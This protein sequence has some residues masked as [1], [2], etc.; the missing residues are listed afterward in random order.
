MARRL[1]IGGLDQLLY[2]LPL[3][4]RKRL[5]WL[6]PFSGAM[7]WIMLDEP[8]IGQDRATRQ[9]LSAVIL[10]LSRVGHGI[11]V[12]THDDEFAGTIPH[13]PLRITDMT[14]RAA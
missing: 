9:A 11:I 3:A 8:T 7:P 2:E 13:Q 1:G 4:A 14:I 10:L 6:W 5:S 12:V